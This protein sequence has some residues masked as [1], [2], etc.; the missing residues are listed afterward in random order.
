MNAS[1]RRYF[2]KLPEEFK[3]Y[4]GY[5]SGRNKNGFSYSIDENIAKWFSSRFSDN[6]QVK[7][8]TVKK[9]DVFAYL[10]SRNEKEIIYLKNK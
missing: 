3:I 8:I 7:E 4:R 10:S 1:E 9:E 5:Q 2:S 6:V